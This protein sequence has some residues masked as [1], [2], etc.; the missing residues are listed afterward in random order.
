MTYNPEKAKRYWLKHKERILAERQAKRE[1]NIAYQKAYREKNG[2]ELNEKR[3]KERAENPEPLREQQRI[4][5]SKNREKVRAQQA[6][7]FAKHPEIKQRVAKR[8]EEEYQE[9][10]LSFGN[11]Y[12]PNC[13]WVG[14]YHPLMLDF[15][16]VELPRRHS[17]SI[18]PV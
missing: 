16:H 4:R 9:I 1:E 15:H 17:G 6:E 11:C 2:E 18:C 5:Y 10:K 8:R 14:A 3:R 7:Y 13:Q 12:N